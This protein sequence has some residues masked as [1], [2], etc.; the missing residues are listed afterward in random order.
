MASAWM[1]AKVFSGS[2]RDIRNHYAGLQRLR[3]VTELTRDAYSFVL[4]PEES[5]SRYS[6]VFTC[7]CSYGDLVIGLDIGAMYPEYAAE[8]VA[9]VAP[10]EAALREW[11]DWLMT[12]WMDSVERY[13][14]VTL[15][16]THADLNAPPPQDSVG[17]A[18]H[19]N[20]KHGHIAVS[21]PALES[22][23]W[24]GLLVGE[25]SDCLR[26]GLPVEAYTLL[27]G[28]AF[29]LREIRK[30]VRGATL[31]LPALNYQL[32]L[33]ALSKGV[34]INMGRKDEGTDMDA[35]VRTEA[36]RWNTV[37]L[38]RG[39]EDGLELLDELALTVEVVLDRR[40][41]S[42]ADIER[43][44]EGSVYTIPPAISGKAVA[45]CCN[46]RVFARGELVSVE[47][48]LGVLVNESVGDPA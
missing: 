27:D 25:S 45:L 7:A 48:Q 23:P 18:L 26:K 29:P 20:E 1:P 39:P 8:T 13:L 36:G 35:L 37:S 4:N 11:L 10:S 2:V 14:G 19:L 42:L 33:G 24:R 5:L 34:R 43:L 41:I 16:V 46:G 21:G 17:F 28:G 15:S 32:H 40:L 6:L 47:G 30:L 22:I 31:R 38:E 9:R 44:R 3:L 12:P